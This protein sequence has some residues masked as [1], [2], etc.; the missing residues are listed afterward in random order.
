MEATTNYAGMYSYDPLGQSD[1]VGYGSETAWGANVFTAS[2]SQSI[3]AVGFFTH[4]PNTTYTVYAGA[5]LAAS[6]GRGA[7][8]Q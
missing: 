8:A 5:S 6:A 3:A 4:V 1:T 7:R 2:Q